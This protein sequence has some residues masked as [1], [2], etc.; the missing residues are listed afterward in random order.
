[1]KLL[2]LRSVAGGAEDALTPEFPQQIH[3]ARHGNGAFME[4]LPKISFKGGAV[5][6]Y[7]QSGKNGIPAD[8]FQFRKGQRSRLNAPPESIVLPGE[9]MIHPRSVRAK[10]EAGESFFH[11]LA[12]IGVKIQQRIVYI[13]KSGF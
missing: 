6:L 10:P 5:P 1:M 7:A 8:L 3:G 12:H 2:F 9:H 11:G 4:L 13:D